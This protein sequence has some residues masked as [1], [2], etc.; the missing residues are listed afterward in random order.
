MLH[1]L[2]A[3]F[4]EIRQ[5]M[6]TIEEDNGVEADGSQIDERDGSVDEEDDDLRSGGYGSRLNILEAFNVELKHK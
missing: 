6:A 2:E 5:E 1:A 3:Q 4:D